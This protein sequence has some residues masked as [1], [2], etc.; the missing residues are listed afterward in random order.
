MVRSETMPRRATFAAVFALLAIACNALN[1]VGD[2]GVQ[3]ATSTTGAGDASLDGVDRD[4]AGTADT[5]TPPEGD[6]SVIVT[7]DAGIDANGDADASPP[8]GFC[9]ALS[10]TPP[11]LCSDFDGATI[12]PWTATTTGSATAASTTAQARS[13]PRSLGV[14]NPSGSTGRA[15][16]ARTFAGAAPATIT[17]AFSVRADTVA[18]DFTQELAVVFLGT[19]GGNPYQLQLE[20]DTNGALGIE[21]E[22][23]QSDGSVDE[24]NVG[25]GITLPFGQWRRITWTVSIGALTSTTSVAVE[26]VATPA[27]FAV[28]AHQ[29]K[30]APTIHIGHDGTVAT[31]FSVFY[32]DVVVDLK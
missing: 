32:D 2:L 29:Y 21:E 26:G 31:P 5:G 17:F 6:G 30:A 27:S 1:G 28:S 12:A 18:T 20:L 9:A 22:T 3:D 25:L 24:R 7:D 13:A 19:S 10:L 4:G 23:P 16:V 8:L 11:T 15:F 14:A